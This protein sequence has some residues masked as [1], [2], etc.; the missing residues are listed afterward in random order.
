MRAKI[1]YRVRF[2]RQNC[3]LLAQ[4]TWQ[5][6]KKEKNRL[7]RLRHKYRMT[8]INDDT[9]EEVFNLKL[10]RLNIINW[11]GVSVILLIILSISIVAFTPLREYIPGYSD[12]QTKRNAAIAIF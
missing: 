11:V 9:F 8:I 12:V 1:F 5:K 3:A 10:S 7:E 4:P 6:I 2:K